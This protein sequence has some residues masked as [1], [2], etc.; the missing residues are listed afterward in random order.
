MNF[1]AS[2]M[3]L[4]VLPWYLV[5]T[6]LCDL[7][8]KLEQLLVD[9]IPEKDYNRRVELCGGP[10]EEG[11]GFALWRRRFVDHRGDG[12]IVEYAGFEVFDEFT[13]R[14]T[15]EIG[16]FELNKLRHKIER[17]RIWQVRVLDLNNRRWS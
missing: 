10:R 12:E 6:E 15:D 16:L 2:G 3:T 8:I 14:G 9:W 13:Y 1:Y 7:A 5:Q 11:N 17:E 4:D